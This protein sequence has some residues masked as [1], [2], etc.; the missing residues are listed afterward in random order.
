M[1]DGY[2]CFTDHKHMGR[3]ALS[4]SEKDT[5]AGSWCI[6]LFQSTELV[7]HALLYAYYFHDS[8]QTAD[9]TDLAGFTVKP[10]FNIR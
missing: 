3:T 9:D 7:R 8:E 4:I 10:C 1:D 2:R 6:S 5:V